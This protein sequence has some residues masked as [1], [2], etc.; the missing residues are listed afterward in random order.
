[1]DPFKHQVWLPL[2]VVVFISFINAPLVN[3]Y[4]WEVGKNPYFTGPP[5]VQ[6]VDLGTVR[7]SWS[8][9]VEYIECAD[10]FLVKYWQKHDIANYEMTELIDTKQFSVDIQVSPKL[11]YEFVVIARED[12]GSLLGIDYNKSDKKEFK[13]SAYNSNVN[14]TPPKPVVKASD[15]PVPSEVTDANVDNNNFAGVSEVVR[16]E[17]TVENSKLLAGLSIELIGIIIVCS[18]VLLLI[19]VGLI[20]KLTCAKKTEDIDDI[21]DDEDDDDGDE[22]EK[23]RL[24]V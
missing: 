14:P 18:I 1:M 12:K 6:Q 13:T 19:L 16:E 7:V 2:T 24:D 17:S 4:C 22:F 20:Y 9:L 21:D 8:G 15:P 3:A 11:P 10:N 23:E 5:V